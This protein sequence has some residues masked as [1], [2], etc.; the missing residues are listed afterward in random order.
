MRA[1]LLL[2]ATAERALV[3]LTRGVEQLVEMAAHDVEEDCVFGAVTY[4]VANAVGCIEGRAPSIGL[5]KVIRARIACG[6]PPPPASRDAEL[7]MSP[8]RNA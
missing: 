3:V 2:D 8:W 4:V 7:R 1:E 6:V 5:A